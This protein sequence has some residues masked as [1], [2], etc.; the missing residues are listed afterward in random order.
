MTIDGYIINVRGRIGISQTY[1]V[2]A[3]DIIAQPELA[4][5]GEGGDVNF[6]T[7]ASNTSTKGIDFVGTWR[8]GFFDGNL[9]TTLAYNYNKSKVTKFD[10]AVISPEQRDV[11]AHLAPNHRATLSANF[12]RGPW[13][14]NARENYYSWW[15]DELDYPGQK[16][17]TE[18]TTDL[19]ISYDFM[20]HFRVTVGANNIFNNRPDRIANTASN[21]IYVL[22]GSTADGQ[23]Y[24]RLG[25]PFGINGGFWYVRLAAHFAPFDMGAPAP[26]VVPPP[27]PP[28]A[29][30]TCADGS[31]VALGAACPV[32]A[33][34]P[35]PPPPPPTERGERG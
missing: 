10:P 29:T 20:R 14:L 33:P 17:G 18:F 34:P 22:T 35:P 28:P 32:V 30:Q 1:H 23:V 8:T 2:T 3:A 12:V 19:D 6:F 5:V 16:F 26:M 25:G 11:V 15:R 31:V 4:A 9:T 24:P 27:P 21:P 7:N 13:T